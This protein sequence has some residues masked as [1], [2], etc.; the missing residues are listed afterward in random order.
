MNRCKRNCILLIPNIITQN[1]RRKEALWEEQGLLRSYVSYLNSRR[2]W[3]NHAVPWGSSAHGLAFIVL[4]LY[5]EAPKV[6]WKV[7]AP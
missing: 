1:N 5:K 7:W 4:N 2:P 6:N 3:N